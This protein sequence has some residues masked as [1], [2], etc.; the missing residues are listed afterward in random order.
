M[1]EA[2]M[3]Q[4]VLLTPE[5]FLP[6]DL[7][8]DRPDAVEE[9]KRR[10]Q[11]GRLTEQQATGLEQYAV[12]GYLTIDLDLEDAVFD[13]IEQCVERMWKDKPNDIVYAYDGALRRMSEADE[14][15]ERRPP[16]RIMGLES[17]SA[18]AMSL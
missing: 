1:S 11:A 3:D 5:G 4:D 6:S 17:Q 7:W 16:Y 18:A 12:D 10:L 14:E 8:L 9:I 13:D 15:R 2:A